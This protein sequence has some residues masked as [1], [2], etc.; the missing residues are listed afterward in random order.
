MRVF[1]VFISNHLLTIKSMFYRLTSIYD[2][3]DIIKMFK[4]NVFDDIYQGL[5]KI[6]CKC[7]NISKNYYW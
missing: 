7:S 6:N 5:K 4:K 2:C 1:I 3:L